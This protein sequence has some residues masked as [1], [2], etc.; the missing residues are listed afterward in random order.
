[1]IEAKAIG[2]EPGEGV[3]SAAERTYHRRQHL[4]FPGDRMQEV[5][6]VIEGWLLRYVRL[7]SGQRQITGVYLPGDFCEPQWVIDPVSPEWIVALSPTRTVAYPLETLLPGHNGNQ[8]TSREVLADLMRLLGRQSAMVISLGRKS[9]LERLSSVLID[10]YD[11]LEMGH[12][13]GQPA[14]MPLTQ[15]DLADM[16]GLT[17]IHVNRIL[18]ELREHKVL[19]AN[20]G[21]VAVSD[22]EMLRFVSVHGYFGTSRAG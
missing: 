15:G 17:P 19:E 12:G 1:M 22:P 18:K 16:V 2:V 6:R 11:R 7:P 20:R 10:L 21:A 5:H 14:F 9:G 4:A 8:E 3:P 13:N